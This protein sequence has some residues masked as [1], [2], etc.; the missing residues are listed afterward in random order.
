MELKSAPSQAMFPDTW[1]PTVTF[2]NRATFHWNGNT[3]NVVHVENA[4]TDGDSFV[5]FA[6]LNVI[7]TGDTYMK[8]TYPFIDVSSAGSIDRP[9]GRPPGGSIRPRPG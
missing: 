9:P 7:H 8:D 3:V 5:Q 4:H 2:P 1:L 6:N